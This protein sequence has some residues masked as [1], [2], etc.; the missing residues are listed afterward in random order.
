MKAAAPLGVY[1]E[2][3]GARPG[4]QVMKATRWAELGNDSGALVAVHNDGYLNYQASEPG[5]VRILSTVVGRHTKNDRPE[6]PY[7]VDTNTGQP[8]VG[9][10]SIEFPQ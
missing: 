7:R 1:T 5:R 6:A 3:I 9:S 8:F 2:R 10:F 4:E